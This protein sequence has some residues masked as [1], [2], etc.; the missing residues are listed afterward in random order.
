MRKLIITLAWALVPVAAVYAY[1]SVSS[2]SGISVNPPR[3]V[4]YETNSGQ[5][6]KLN[7]ENGDSWYLSK[8][9]EGKLE[10]AFIKN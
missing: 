9:W 5:L 4:I 10:W 8:N 7:T 3:F 1:D 6:I 2:I